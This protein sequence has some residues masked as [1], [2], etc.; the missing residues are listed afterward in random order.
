MK[1]KRLYRIQAILMIIKQNSS[2]KLPLIQLN[3]F[4]N[5]FLQRRILSLR[6]YAVVCCFN[7]R[8]L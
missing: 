1:R 6:K 5:H 8:F 4:I 2:Q 3:V 7:I